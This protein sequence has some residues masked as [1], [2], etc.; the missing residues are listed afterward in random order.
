MK[1]RTWPQGEATG[2]DGV[3]TDTRERQMALPDTKIGKRY[4]EDE[5]EC[6]ASCEANLG[7]S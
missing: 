4:G 6:P 7:F 2:V 1:G 3:S 5:R